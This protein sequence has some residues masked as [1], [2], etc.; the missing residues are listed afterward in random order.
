LLNAS[1]LDNGKI[2][3]FVVTQSED[4]PAKKID[5][6]RILSNFQEIASNNNQTLETYTLDR[7]DDDILVELNTINSTSNDVLVFYYAGHG[8]SSEDEEFPSF[9]NRLMEFSQNSVHEMLKN[10]PHKLV[11]TLY[12]TC[13]QERPNQRENNRPPT[14]KPQKSINVALVN[15]LFNKSQG[16]V[17]LCSSKYG[18]YTGSNT[19][20]GG[21]FTYSFFTQLKKFETDELE[22]VENIWELFAAEVQSYT[23]I[24]CSKNNYAEQYPQFKGNVMTAETQQNVMPDF[25]YCPRLMSWYDVIEYSESEYNQVV[26]LDELLLW[27]D[28]PYAY[29]F[30]ANE[31]VWLAPKF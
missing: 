3:L 17:M 20:I 13:N 30:K 11:L 12:D 22:T 1:T 31:L 2:I 5:K 24:T 28:K 23:N 29:K 15:M 25:F 7:F 9:T 16:D 10:K 26:T 27:N 8:M 6:S 14:S 4:D 19:R 21:F 18:Y